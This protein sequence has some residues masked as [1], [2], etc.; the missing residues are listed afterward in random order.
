MFPEVDEFLEVP[1]DDPQKLLFVLEK[2]AAHCGGQSVP[3][4][5]RSICNYIGFLMFVGRKI[6]GD[7]HRFFGVETALTLHELSFVAQ[8]IYRTLFGC[9]MPKTIEG[10][11]DALPQM[12]L[13]D[14]VEIIL[15]VAERGDLVSVVGTPGQVLSQKSAAA[16]KSGANDTPKR[17]GRPPKAKKS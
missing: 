2:K 4:Q 17:R 3:I 16:P 15:Q 6:S 14:A 10:V 7:K 8:G 9:S 11:I 1:D 12:V 5:V 13:R